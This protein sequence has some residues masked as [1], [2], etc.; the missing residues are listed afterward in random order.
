VKPSNID[1]KLKANIESF[2]KGKKD[3]SVQELNDIK[4][5]LL[6]YK[7]ALESTQFFEGNLKDNRVVSCFA[8]GFYD[9]ILSHMLNK[10]NAAIAIVVVLTEKKILLKS[11]NNVC[12]I[13]LCNLA[14]LLCD[15]DCINSSTDT[16]EGKITEKFLNL[17]KTFRQCS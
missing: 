2:K 9:E 16:A 4:L 17:T 5:Y 10:L 3:F 1:N 11:N 8:E 7:D 14:K 6:K 12:A 13:N 15:G